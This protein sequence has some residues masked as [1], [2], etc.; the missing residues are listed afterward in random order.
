MKNRFIRER[1]DLKKGEG[2]DWDLLC[3]SS[4]YKE[5]LRKN[6]G[7]KEMIQSYLNASKKLYE[8]FKRYNHPDPMISVIWSDPL[9]IPFLFLCRHT[10]ELSIKYYLENHNIS[11]NSIHNIKKLYKKTNIENQEYNELIQAF[12]TL[13][14]TGT[15]LRY[16]VD[17]SDNEYRNKPYFIKSDEIIIYVEKLCNELLQSCNQ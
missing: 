13:D 8:I 16:S 10:I 14:K 15:M 1:I 3:T 2:H 17:N 6:S 12:N 5:N 11:F 9:C 4:L 7:K